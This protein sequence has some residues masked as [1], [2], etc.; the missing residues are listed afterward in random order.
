[1]SRY[2]L[3]SLCPL[4]LLSLA[5]AASAAPGKAEISASGATAGAAGTTAGAP[6]GPAS[7]VPAW[8]RAYA[9]S[10]R[11]L[12]LALDE[13][14]NSLGAGWGPD[15]RGLGF[16]LHQA[17]LPVAALLPLPEPRLDRRLR[18]ALL[19]LESGADACMKAM[20]MTTRLRLVEGARALADLEAGLAALSPDCPVGRRDG[21]AALT[22]VVGVEGEGLALADTPLGAARPQGS[23]AAPVAARSADKAPAKPKRASRGSRPSRP[24]SPKPHRAG[25]S[26]GRTGTAARP[27]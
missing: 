11:P 6:A 12:H 3:K 26:G 1:M 10:A 25:G 7:P 23:T 14:L 19:S 21:G 16:P 22:L 2:A 9:P 13:A 15:S 5:I 4:L 27:Q 8:C 20:P 17:L 24:S 18:Q